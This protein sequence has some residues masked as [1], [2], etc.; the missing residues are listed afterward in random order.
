[1][2]VSPFVMMRVNK[3]NFDISSILGSALEHSE[4]IS[5]HRVP[6]RNKEH[7]I[8]DATIQ[9]TITPLF[10]SQST[11]FPVL[12]TWVGRARKGPTV[13]YKI[14]LRFRRLVILEDR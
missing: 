14:N 11:D 8:N 9:W 13:V 5:R 3:A 10:Y 7:G 6:A 4:Q 12:R 1:M 2:F